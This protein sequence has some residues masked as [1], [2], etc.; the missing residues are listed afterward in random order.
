MEGWRFCPPPVA[1]QGP[2]A[3][4]GMPPSAPGILI[5]ATRWT[6]HVYLDG[7]PASVGR[8]PLLT[9]RPG[10]SRQLV[11]V[12]GPHRIVATLAQRIAAGAVR[13]VQYDRQIQI[14]PRD[15]SFRLQLSEG[16]FR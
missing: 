7:E 8:P 13:P 11:L 3:G 15:R 1:W 10:E 9:L 14:D 6:V 5:N 2:P 16:D 4:M 12:A